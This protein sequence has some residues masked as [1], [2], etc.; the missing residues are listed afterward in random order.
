MKRWLFAAGAIVLVCGICLLL[1]S[2]F[3]II[4]T[5]TGNCTMAAAGRCFENPS[6][7][8]QW[9]PGNTGYAYKIKEIQYESVLLS[10]K[11]PDGSII[12]GQMRMAPLGADSILIRWTCAAP[13]GWDLLNQL[14]VYLHAGDIRRN[15]AIILDSMSSFVGKPKNI[16][17]VGFYRTLSNDTT[18]LTIT[19]FGAAY[20]TIAEVYSRVDSC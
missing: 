15:M 7:W 20:P 1:L 4:T 14:N 10:A 5:V 16:Y 18:L 3:T 17:G 2:R 11:C 9:W 8:P 12:D 6:R 19:S 13:G